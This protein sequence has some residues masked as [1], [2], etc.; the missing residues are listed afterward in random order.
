MPN[1]AVACANLG[2]SLARQGQLDDGEHYT[3]QAL[4][5]NPNYADAHTN[6]AI[7]WLMRGDFARVAR[8]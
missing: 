4:R 5:I 7:V 8:V 1:D 2:T 6:Q 3:Q